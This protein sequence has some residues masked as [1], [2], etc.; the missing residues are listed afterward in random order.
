MSDVSR[1][2]GFALGLDGGGS[3]TSCTVLDSEENILGQGTAGPSNPLRTGFDAAF[4][5]LATAAAQALS[6]AQLKPQQVSAVCAGLAG[7]GSRSVVRSAIVFLTREFPYALTH[8]T[9]DG[10]VALEAAVGA[11]EGVALL[12]GTGSLVLGRNA[13]GET[14]RTGGYGRWIGDEGSAYEMGRRAVG[15]V[16]RARDLAAPVTLLADMIPA[17]LQS[18]S[19]DDLRDRI[20]KDPD[21]V[22]PQI[23]PVLVAAAKMEDAAA[24]EILFTAAL[25]LSSMVL[26]VVRRLGMRESEFPLVKCGG[27]F[28]HS[29]I[30]D[31]MLDSLLS[32]G[33]RGARTS[34][35]EVSPSLGAARL[36]ARLAREE[37]PA[38]A[39]GAS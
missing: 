17:A 1:K 6:L 3:G 30:L 4:R 38:K 35:L 33:I 18:P 9:T 5:Q 13:L 37:Q 21:Q 16:A 22:F 14:A 39:H 11:G 15:C 31:G 27:V 10:E 20:A 8:V 7:A 36:A 23:F 32:S 12:S 2:V 24:R 19:W 28:G 25:Q 26:A 29:S 34:R